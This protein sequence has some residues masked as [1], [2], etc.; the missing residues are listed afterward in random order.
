MPTVHTEVQTAS[1]GR[2]RRRSVR[3]A[4]MTMTAVSQRAARSLRSLPPRAPRLGGEQ[5]QQIA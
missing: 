4:V 2:R 5:Q 1:L 3:V